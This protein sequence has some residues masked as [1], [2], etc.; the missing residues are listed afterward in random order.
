MGPTLTA[1]VLTI[2]AGVGSMG[3]LLVGGLLLGV[4]EAMTAW[5]GGAMWRDVTTL[6]VLLLLLRW[7]GR[8]A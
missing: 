7:R 2:F 5:V 4:V 6:A 1:I 3:G 8:V